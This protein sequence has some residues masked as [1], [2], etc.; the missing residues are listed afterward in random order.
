LPPALL[1]QNTPDCIK[2]QIHAVVSMPIQSAVKKASRQIAHSAED[3]GRHSYNGVLLIV[4]DGY[5]YLNAENFEHLVVLRCR[6]AFG[7]FV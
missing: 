3:L 5:S 7:V 6:N 1:V 4:N 2:R